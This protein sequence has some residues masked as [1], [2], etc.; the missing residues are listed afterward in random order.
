[1]AVELGASETT[2]RRWRARDTVQDRSHTSYRLATI[3]KPMQ[4]FVVVELRKWLSPPLDDPRAERT[5]RA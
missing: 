5:L 4:A 1:L 3:L 2:V